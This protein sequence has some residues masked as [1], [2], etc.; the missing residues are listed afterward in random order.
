MW[1]QPLSRSILMRTGFFVR[2]MQNEVNNVEMFL[3]SLFVKKLVF[4]RRSCL[5]SYFLKTLFVL[6][7]YTVYI[8]WTAILEK[9]P[10]KLSW[11]LMKLFLSLHKFPFTYFGIRLNVTQNLRQ[12]IHTIKVLTFE[13]YHNVKKIRYP[14]ASHE[15]YEKFEK[16][17]E[18]FTYF[19]WKSCISSNAFYLV[20]SRVFLFW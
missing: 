7:L 15:F 12:W 17:Q 10:W 3:L 19:E 2:V 6:V 8:T 11:I 9:P 4:W 5:V 13:S 18:F 16:K 20:N 14:K 1:F